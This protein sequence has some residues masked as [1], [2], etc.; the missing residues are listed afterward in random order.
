MREN[1]A[2]ARA[3]ARVLPACLREAEVGETPLMAMTREAF[4]QLDQIFGIDD[5]DDASG[6]TLHCRPT[7]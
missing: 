5:E 6:D 3:N 1:Y 2:R 4:D 7:G